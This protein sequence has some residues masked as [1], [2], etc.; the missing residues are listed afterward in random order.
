MFGE[1]VSEINLETL[2]SACA[3]PVLTK[4]PMA[5]SRQRGESSSPSRS[6]SRPRGGSRHTKHSDQRS[7]SVQADESD[8]KSFTTVTLGQSWLLPSLRPDGD[9]GDGGKERKESVSTLGGDQPPIELFQE[10]QPFIM[11][12]RPS[13]PSAFD[14]NISAAAGD[15]DSRHDKKHSAVTTKHKSNDKNAN[16]MNKNHSTSMLMPPSHTS[17]SALKPNQSMDSFEKILSENRTDD[18]RP[19][20]S[21]HA[22]PVAFDSL[23]TTNPNQLLLLSTKKSKK[24]TKNNMQAPTAKSSGAFFFPMLLSTST[25]ILNIGPSGN[26]S[27]LLYSAEA[28]NDF[29][30]NNTSHF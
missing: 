30:Y 16:H 22:L 12:S 25:P 17:T 21:Q 20:K 19:I 24:P 3:V 7:I 9:G 26:D 23:S 29:L 5:G 14:A 8:I 28:E 27:S 4:P 6:R 18:S 11:V 15:R 13:S 10:P 2:R 1:A